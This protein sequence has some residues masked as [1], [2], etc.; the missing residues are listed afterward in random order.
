MEAVLED[1]RT[2]P[3]GDDMKA[4]LTLV[5]SV[6]RASN[7]IGPEEIERA[8]EAGWSESALFDAVTVTAL[9]NFYNIWVDA[10]G[11]GDLPAAAYHHSGERL[12]ERGYVLPEE[13]EE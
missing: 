9:F 7:Q 3:I 8:K 12:A 10:T 6:N 2:A 4:L 11:V 5:E 13:R 1:H